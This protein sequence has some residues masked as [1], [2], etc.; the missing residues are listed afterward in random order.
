MPIHKV[1][2]MGVGAG[3]FPGPAKDGAFQ[4]M[5]FRTDIALGTQ[6][7]IAA[8]LQLHDANVVY[9]PGACLS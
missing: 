1:R 6:D 3:R 8:T 2:F 7:V 9:P 5:Y 4:Y